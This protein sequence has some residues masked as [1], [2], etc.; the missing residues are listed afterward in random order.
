[1]QPDLAVAMI[2]AGIADFSLQR[3]NET[4]YPTELP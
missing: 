3:D 1:M 4:G 2:D